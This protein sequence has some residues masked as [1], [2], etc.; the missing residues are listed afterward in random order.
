MVG[1]INL[2]RFVN[3]HAAP[4]TGTYGGHMALLPPNSLLINGRRTDLSAAT[5]NIYN[6][7]QEVREE[8]QLTGQLSGMNLTSVREQVQRVAATVGAPSAANPAKQSKQVRVCGGDGVESIRGIAFSLLGYMG[9]CY[10][11]AVGV[12]S[13]CTCVS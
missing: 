13:R 2:E 10:V 4:C 8:L 11:R 7:L 6:V 5:F 3:R 1:L 9:I 12:V